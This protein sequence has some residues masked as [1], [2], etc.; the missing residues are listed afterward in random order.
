MNHLIYIPSL[1]LVFNEKN[2]SKEL[3]MGLNNKVVKSNSYAGNKPF[4]ETPKTDFC[5]K[6]K[7]FLLIYR[8]KDS[9]A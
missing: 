8:A 3:V 9:F 4:Q 1:L 5:Y 6:F 7:Y 2:L